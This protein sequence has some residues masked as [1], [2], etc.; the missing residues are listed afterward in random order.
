VSDQKGVDR[1]QELARSVCTPFPYITFPKA[2]HCG[3]LSPLSQ[4]L[5]PLPLAHADPV[6]GPSEPCELRDA[7][8]SNRY[9]D[10]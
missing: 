2:G 8:E 5:Y 10:Y 6:P 4:G 7:E 3:Q 1:S 9:G